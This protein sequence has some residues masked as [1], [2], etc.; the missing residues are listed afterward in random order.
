M[1]EARLAN[2]PDDGRLVDAGRLSV[3]DADAKR[4]EDARDGLMAAGVGREAARTGKKATNK[5]YAD[6]VRDGKAKR[7]RVSHAF[8]SP[9]MDAMLGEFRA[10]AAGLT[11]GAPR[12][13]IVSD[14][15]GTV[16]SAA[17]LADP[18]YWVRHIR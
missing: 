17:E 5:A 9:H 3:D 7:L 15:T 1:P 6:A 8:H 14:V 4:L 18:D 11:Y 10:V 16:A 2:D 13:P 12:I